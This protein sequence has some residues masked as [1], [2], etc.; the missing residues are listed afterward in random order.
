MGAAGGSAGTASRALSRVADTAHPN[1]DKEIDKEIDMLMGTV[2]RLNLGKSAAAEYISRR[3]L[4]LMK[5]ARLYPR[6]PDFET[7]E[8]YTRLMGPL[9]GG[10]LRTPTFDKFVT[11]FQKN[12]AYVLKQGRLM[13]EEVSARA[14]ASG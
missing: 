7:L 2:D 1:F 4:Q 3:A 6:S 14:K 8:P 11:E 10:A 9:G 13:Q 12:E 5:V